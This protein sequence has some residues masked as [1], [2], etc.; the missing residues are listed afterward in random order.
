MRGLVTRT[1]SGFFWVQTETG[2]ELVCQL[3]G[4][5]KKGSRSED[6]AA[7]GDQVEVSQE[8]AERGLIESILPRRCLFGRQSPDSGGAYQQVLIANPDQVAVVFACQQPAPRLGMLD[9]FLVIAERQGIPPL[10]VVNKVDLVDIDAA[11]E[12]FV[13]Y[14]RL[15]Y[16]IH[17]ASA[18]TGLGIHRLR[19]RLRDQLTLFTG[20]SGVGKS[21]LLNAIQPGLG[22]AARAVSQVGLR[23]GRHTTVA[24]ELFPLTGGGWVADTPGLRALALWDIQPEELDAYFPELRQRV[25][26]CAF[27]N[28]SHLHEP[29]CAVLQALQTGEIHPLRYE[30]YR[31]MRLGEVE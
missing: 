10:L 13:Q 23:K 18:R 17:Y 3:R 22:L 5:L 7:I 9:R 2:V 16:E 26:N 30:S 1:Q 19:A 27:S 15:G 12:L 25:G 8:S 6:L 4:R 21:S 29:G 24:R 20:P 14:A 28:C 11:Q 31:R